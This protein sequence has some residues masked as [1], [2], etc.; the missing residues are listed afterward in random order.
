MVLLKNN[1]GAPRPGKYSGDQYSYCLSVGMHTCSKCRDQAS[2]S[3]R[4]IVKP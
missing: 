2:K 4:K 1:K 3:N